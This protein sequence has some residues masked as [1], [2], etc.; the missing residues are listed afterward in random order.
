MLAKLQLILVS[1]LLILSGAATDVNTNNHSVVEWMRNAKE[2]FLNVKELGCKGDGIKDDAPCINNAISALGAKGGT[3]YFPPGIYNV[4]STINL[5]VATPIVIRGAGRDITR[6]KLKNGANTDV[7]RTAGFSSYTMTGSTDG[8]TRVFIE[9]LTIDGNKANNSSGYGVRLYGY[10]IGMTNVDVVNCK[11]DGIYT[12]WYFDRVGGGGANY[13]MG[14]QFLFVRSMD[15]D[16]NGWTFRGP[17]DSIIMGYNGI[18]NQ[19]WGFKNEYSG[20]KGSL[21]DGNGVHAV[22]WNCYNNA[23]GGIDFET[24]VNGYNISVSTSNSTTALKLGTKVGLATLTDMLAGGGVGMELGGSDN[25][26]NGVIVNSTTGLVLTRTYSSR[27]A[28]TLWNNKTAVDYNNT[29]GDGDLGDNQFTFIIHAEKDQ[30]PSRGSGVSSDY[31]QIR[32][33]SVDGKCDGSASSYRLQLP[34]HSV[35]AG[36]MNFTETTTFATT[37]QSGVAYA[38]QFLS[39]RMSGNTGY[40]TMVGSG[41]SASGYLGFH[42]GDNTRLGYLGNGSTTAIVNSRL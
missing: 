29:H 20:E 22:Q 4:G 26:I 15:N 21:Y 6:V 23:K 37:D 18:G 36:G 8:N 39:R 1:L 17:H 42:K 41:T 24:G 2:P 31:L 40:V 10:F 12:E 32:C 38:T 9:D 35:I 5:P 33:T 30:I 13:D 16:G 14:G 27:V 11:N 7:F 3:V 25:S 19:G 34:V 28:V